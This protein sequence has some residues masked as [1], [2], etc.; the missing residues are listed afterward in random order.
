MPKERG[1]ERNSRHFAV[2]SSLF[3]NLRL[4]SIVSPRPVN[5]YHNK[6]APQLGTG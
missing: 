4:D 1:L 3:V 5:G 6:T 2:L